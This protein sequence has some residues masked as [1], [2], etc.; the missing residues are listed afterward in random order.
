M[1]INHLRA[2]LRGDDSG[3]SI[4]MALGLLVLLGATFLVVLG[5]ATNQ[6][7]QS[8]I[9][10]ETISN[11]QGNDA[12]IQNA[13]DFLNDRISDT[14][15][16][17]VDEWLVN[18][19]SG[20]GVV[21]PTGPDSAH[22]FTQGNTK[23]EWY[24]T[25][26][27]DHAIVHTSATTMKR[28][29]EREYRIVGKGVSSYRNGT[30]G[31]VYN[32]SPLGAWSDAFAVE[33]IDGTDPTFVVNGTVG[34]Y[35]KETLSG[36][37]IT[38]AGQF[39]RYDRRAEV[40]N[41]KSDVKNFPFTLDLNGKYAQP[42]EAACPVTPGP[43]YHKGIWKVG[44][45]GQFDGNDTYTVNTAGGSVVECHL[46]ADF[47]A[48][49]TLTVTGGGVYTVYV[50]DTGSV[51]RL[52]GKITSVGTSQ[53]HFIFE[54]SR[55]AENAGR[56]VVL[57]NTVD[58][59]AQTGTFIFAPESTC[60]AADEDRYAVITGSVVCKDFA[61]SRGLRVTHVQPK[62]SPGDGASHMVYSLDY[63]E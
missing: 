61:S 25:D 50:R 33:R 40:T 3:Y 4:M 52:A 12:A 18:K 10:T 2:R 46:G 63:R 36:S 14:S 13:L 16:V 7:L 20:G 9:N 6:T 21:I 34:V 43:G 44:G 24:L 28:T 37:A 17:P 58:E 62:A 11:E 31:S 45:F 47:P 35:Y 51:N 39:N 38:G 26:N 60:R 22:K 29:T 54:G 57:G 41:P 32:V 5:A 59:V 15:A 55:G 30:E 19:N 8:R 48:E 56:D 53:V 49:K 27:G 42:T 23:Y 1:N